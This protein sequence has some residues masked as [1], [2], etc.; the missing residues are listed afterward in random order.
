MRGRRNSGAS[1][2]ESSRCSSTR[3]FYACPSN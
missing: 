2:R 3:P 1:G